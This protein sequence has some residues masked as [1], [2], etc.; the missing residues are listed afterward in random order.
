MKTYRQTIYDSNNSGNIA[1][2]NYVGGIMGYG[3]ANYK[4]SMLSGSTSTGSVN[5]NSKTGH[6]A[7]ELEVIVID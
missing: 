7:G 1:G 6:T 2:K 4:G 3:R 5:G